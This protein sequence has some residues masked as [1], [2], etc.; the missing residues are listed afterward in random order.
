[1]DKVK[2]EK[3]K[4]HQSYKLASGEGVPGVTTVLNLLAKPALL[5]WAWEQGRAGLDFR[6]TSSAAADVGTIAH[7]LIECHLKGL[8]PDTSEF[9][10]VDLAA[11]ENAEI[12]FLSWW[13]GQG[14]T[15][16]GCELQLVST[17]YGYGGTLDILTRTREGG[18]CL[19]DLKTSKGIYDEYWHQVAAYGQIWNELNPRDPITKYVICRIGKQESEADFEVQERPNVAKNLR[20]FLATLEVF[21]A[22]K[23][24]K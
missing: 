2:F 23:A 20:V 19:V 21:K 12:K 11:A 6:K 5:K 15:V 18:A 24:L 4:A 8:D 1:M 16:V 9:S 7:W 17:V 3:T 14:M 22:I 13:D 10:P